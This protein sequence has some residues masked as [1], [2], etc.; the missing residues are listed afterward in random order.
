M[1]KS[2]FYGYEKYFSQLKDVKPEDLNA[3]LKVTIK[4]DS[5]DS[6]VKRGFL[7]G[8]EREKP[9]LIDLNFINIEGIKDHNKDLLIM[10]G[11]EYYLFVL[12][13]QWKAQYGYRKYNDLVDYVGVKYII[14]QNID[15]LEIT[16]KVKDPAL[17]NTLL[18]NVFIALESKLSKRFENEEA[19]HW[20]AF[21]QKVDQFGIRILTDIDQ[22]KS[23]RV[24]VFSFINSIYKIGLPIK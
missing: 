23:I 19:N 17:I 5:D 6:G 24:P 16:P 11:I 4:I 3:S 1:K 9:P 15:K 12:Y 13:A 20:W 22:E 18:F 21:T 10:K 14:T 8:N 2:I 7:S